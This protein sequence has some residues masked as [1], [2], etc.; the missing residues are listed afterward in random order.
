MMKDHIILGVSKEDGFG[1]PIFIVIILHQVAVI[2]VF[3]LLLEK[4]QLKKL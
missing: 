3:Q 1:T 2:G 4:P